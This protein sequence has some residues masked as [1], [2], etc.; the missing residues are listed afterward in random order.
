MSVCPCILLQRLSSFLFLKTVSQF[1]YLSN[2]SI[3]YKF[4]SFEI[5]VFSSFLFLHFF[6][7]LFV[8]D[9]SPSSPSYF[10]TPFHFISFFH[11]SFIFPSFLPL[12]SFFLS[13]F[14]FSD[15]D[16][17]S[18]LILSFIYFQILIHDYFSS[19]EER[20]DTTVKINM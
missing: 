19:S 16:R 4:N 15:S 3:I 12:F 18:C 5:K 8:S 2:R 6:C 9:P 1:F 14:F 17:I 10:S 13:S 11:F 7:Y 20:Q